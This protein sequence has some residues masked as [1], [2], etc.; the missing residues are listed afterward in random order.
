[1]PN[2]HI[3]PLESAFHKS[4]N[5]KENDKAILSTDTNILSGNKGKNIV[6]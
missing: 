4:G 1:M 2:Q 3:L 5:N 6:Q